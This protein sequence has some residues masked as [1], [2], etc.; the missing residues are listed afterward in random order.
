MA[1]PPVCIIDE[2]GI[3]QPTFDA[4]LAYYAD[5]YRSIYGQ[6]VYIDP[7]SQDGQWIGLQAMALHAANSQTVAAYNAFSPLTAQGIGLSRLVKIN[8]LTR[9]EATPSTADVRI[10]GQAFTLIESGLVG[11]D[12]GSLWTLP[13]TVIIPETGEITV[14]A[15]CTVLG[16]VAAP[17]NTLTTIQTPTAGWQQVSNPT[18]ATPGAPVERDAALRQRQALSTALPSLSLLD[19]LVGAVA[20]VPGVAR[21]LA[22]E[23]TADAPDAN[24]LPGHSISLVV[25]GGDADAIA[26]L[27]ARKKGPAVGTYGST[28]R[29]VTGSAGIPR[30]I[31]FFRPTVVPISYAI[32]LQNLG[33]YTL[34]IDAQIKAA[35]ADWTNARDLGE[36]VYRDEAFV[37]AKLSN[38]TGSKTYKIVSFAIARDGAVPTPTDARIAF[39]EAASCDPSA[40]TIAVLPA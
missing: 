16:A 32:T 17:A 3:H 36:T 40:V 18:A 20:G 7:D 12:D 26:T 21:L 9:K 6:D 37:P 5:G 29:T 27:I 15:T 2:T 11:G 39:N 33:G 34:A 24:G 10:V 25:D 4:C 35:L 19:G 13:L 8:G 38:G 23:N 31:A 1:T 28:T 30:R 22:Y 14:T